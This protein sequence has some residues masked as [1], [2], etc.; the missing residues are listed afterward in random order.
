MD[1]DRTGQ[2]HRIALL[3]YVDKPLHGRVR[4]PGFHDQG[5]PMD[6]QRRE[7]D[8]P[9]PRPVR[10]DKGRYD[11]K[12]QTGRRRGSNYP[13]GY[14]SERRI[15]RCTGGLRRRIDDRQRHQQC[16]GDPH[17]RQSRRHA[18]DARRY[19][20]MHQVH[21]HRRRNERRRRHQQR[22]CED[23]S[24]HQHSQ[25]GYGYE[26]RR[27]LRL[28]ARCGNQT[29]LL[30]QQRRNKRSHRTRRR[31]GRHAGRQYDRRERH[32][33]RQ[34]DQQRNDTGRCHRSIRR[35]QGLLQL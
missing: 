28:H 7:R 11:Q 34:L 13:R 32:G 9:S 15:G 25:R 17:G 27:H 3:Q 26:H 14:E 23:R 1:S 22:R 24:H 18:D 31:S 33:D 30:H 29:Q 6:L 20:R 35:Q 4:R 5:N 8:D 10:S 19:R 2:G 12:P 21:D 16:L